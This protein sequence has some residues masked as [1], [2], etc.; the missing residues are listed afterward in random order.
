MPHQGLFLQR[1]FHQ[2]KEP[3]TNIIP[4]NIS[5]QENAQS[6]TDI[7]LQMILQGYLFLSVMPI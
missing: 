5:V 7:D 2:G 6:A 1:M 3:F 4:D